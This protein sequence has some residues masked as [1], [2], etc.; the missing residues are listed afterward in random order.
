MFYGT[1]L[2]LFASTLLASASGVY[3]S[4][5]TP[6]TLPWNTY[7]YCNAPH[8]N[9]AHYEPPPNRTGANLVHVSVVMRHHKVCHA[10]PCKHCKEAPPTNIP[11]PRDCDSAHQTTSRLLNVHS[12]HPQAGP[13]PTRRFSSP[14]I[15]AAPQS[16]TMP[17]RPPTTRS[18]PRSGPAPAMLDSS[19]PVGFSTR[20]DTEK[21]VPASVHGDMKGKKNL[22]L[23]QDLW[24]LYHD[25][26]GFLCAVDP[27]EI[28]VRT[29]TEDRTMQVAGA[30]LAAM[31][32]NVAGK[33]WSVHTQPTSVRP[34]PSPSRRVLTTMT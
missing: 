30:M 15:S 16:R 23:E 1:S 28:W 9:A 19:R 20:H 7:N 5:E 12:I 3:D 6:L 2:V 25:K 27:A 29:S 31:D 34:H 22:I 8:V 32:P 13:V 33:P 10:V 24:E 26:L 11:V 18:L 21:C 14:T 4:S 17:R